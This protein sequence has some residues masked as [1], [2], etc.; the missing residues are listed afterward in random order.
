YCVSGERPD[1]VTSCSVVTVGSVAKEMRLPGAGPKRTRL[2]V[3]LS[4][5]QRTATLVGVP[6]CR[7]G[8]RVTVAAA[9][10][11]SQPGASRATSASLVR[12]LIVTARMQMEQ[13]IRLPSKFEV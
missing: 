9:T 6:I 4:V 7:Y 8:P 1:T 2:S 5:R 10:I 11:W 3:A 12:A 13:F